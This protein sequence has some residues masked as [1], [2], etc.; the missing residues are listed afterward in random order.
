MP[1]ER[2]VDF[3]GLVEQ[4]GVLYPDCAAGHKHVPYW[5]DIVIRRADSLDP[6]GVG[7]TGLIQLVNCLPLSAPNHSVLT[8]DLGELVTADGCACGRRGKAFVFKGRA[9]AAE[10]RG[11]SDVIRY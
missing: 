10:V 8:E 11:C 1:A 3:Y 4:V 7:E 9:P 5:A 6:A 2:V